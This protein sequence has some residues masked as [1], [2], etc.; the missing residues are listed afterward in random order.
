MPSQNKQ[1]NRPKPEDILE[2]INKESRGKLTVFLGA[3][4]GVGKTYAMLEAAH[5]RL[6]EG[7]DIVIGW[8]ETH[9]RQETEKLA[10][11]LARIPAKA[12]EYRDKTLSEMDIDAILERKPQLV[13]V[14]ELAHANIPGSRTC[15]A[16]SGCRGAS[17][18]RHQCLHD[19]EY[20]A[21]RKPE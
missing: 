13:L 1:E 10:E 11:G 20:P 18:G 16:L 2:R 6:R 9:G 7:I 3:A 5:D 21:H 4:A 12:L 14:D 17:E 15:T 8:V 19:A